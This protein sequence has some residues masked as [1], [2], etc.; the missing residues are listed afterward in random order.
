M[1]VNRM[2]K[3]IAKFD[4]KNIQEIYMEIMNNYP[5][6]GERFLYFL[7]FCQNLDPDIDLEA[8]LKL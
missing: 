1:L 5:K 7:F 6:Y 2:A 8:T 3:T 4:L